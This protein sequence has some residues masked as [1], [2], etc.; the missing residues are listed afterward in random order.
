[1]ERNWEKV[2]TC[3]IQEIITL[4][5]NGIYVFHFVI[6]PGTGRTGTLLALDICMRSL[7]DTDTVDVLGTVHMLRQDRAGAVQTQEQYFFIYEVS[8]K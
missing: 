6:S 8:A 5:N 4:A 1:M 7:D 3:V 2:L